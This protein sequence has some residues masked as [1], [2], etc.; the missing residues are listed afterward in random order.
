MKNFAYK[1][2]TDLAVQNKSLNKGISYKRNNILVKRFDQ[3]KY[4]YTNIIFNNIE[5]NNN[6]VNLQKVFILEL[7][8]YFNKYNIT[9]KSSV[10][11]VGL[12][13][14]NIAS[15]SLGVKTTSKIKATGYLKD[16]NL[17]YNLR[18][19]YTFIPGVIMN[20]GIMTF[21]SINAIKKETKPD[22]LIIIDSLVSS[23]IEYLNRLIQITDR[24]IV[25]GSGVSNY[26][27]EISINSIKIP[28]ISIGVPFVTHAYTI[29]RDV[30]NK[31]EDELEYKNGYD[32]LVASKDVDVVV[33][34]ISLILSEA[35]ND[36][37]N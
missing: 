7:R 14:S 24:G 29:I 35:I 12:G 1:I 31:S 3:K 33:D 11:V 4:N 22:F 28:V 37:L 30:L 6:I 32:L 34:K 9:D 17:G 27:K 10:L 19:V 16:L 25:P 15:D 2:R 23:S 13:N 21:D 20:S 36:I 5:S 18:S 8:R 26:Q